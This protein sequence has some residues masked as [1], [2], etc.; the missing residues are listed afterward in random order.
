MFN[1]QQVDLGLLIDRHAFTLSCTLLQNRIAIKAHALSDT[2]ACGY[3]FLDSDFAV[4][5]C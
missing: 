1:L 4:D 3:V 5:L 2:G